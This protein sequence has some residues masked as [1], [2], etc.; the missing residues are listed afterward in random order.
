M[1]E[2]NNLEAV[3][4]AAAT[5]QPAPDMRKRKTKSQEEREEGQ[6][7]VYL[8]IDAPIVPLGKNGVSIWLLDE[9]NQ[10]TCVKP[11]ELGKGLL[12]LL[13]G[14]EWLTE[15]FPQE[16]LVPGTGKNGKKAEFFV[17]GFDQNDAQMAII[18]A[19]RVK[20]I[21][22][23]EGKVFGRGAHRGRDDDQQLLLHMGNKVLISSAGDWRRGS[24]KV[25]KDRIDVRVE[26][27][28][29]IG[30][31][32]YP[33]DDAL[34]P[35]ASE[36]SSR[37][38]AEQLLKL[39]SKWYFVDG[40]R[41]GKPGPAEYLLLGMVGQM[42]ICGAL[43][44]RSHVWLAGPTASGKSSLQRVIRAI[45]DDWVLRAEDASEAAIRQ[46]LNNDTLAVMI[47]EAEAADNPERQRAMM[48][49]AKKSS[50]GG[51]IL[52]GGA[53]HKGQEFTAQSAFLFSSVLHTPMLGED[54]N[55]F[56]ILDM[57]QVP[58]TIEPFEVGPLLPLWRMVGRKM[59][60][61]M[62]EQWPRFE[63]TLATY[64]REIHSHGYEGRWQD[65][66]G[67]LLACADML[68]FDEAPAHRVP[69][70]ENDITEKL[71]VRMVLPL[72][73]RG[74]VEARSDDE[75]VIA[76]LLSLTIPGSN[77]A[78]AETIGQW[79]IRALE[80]R[81]SESED[82]DRREAIDNPVNHVARNRLKS[83]G[84]RLVTLDKDKDGKMRTGDPLINQ[85]EGA[86]L[87]VA[88]PTCKPLSDLFARTEWANGAWVQSM[89]KINGAQKGLKMRFSGPNADN[90]IAIPLMA[91]K[92]Q[93]NDR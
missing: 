8:P 92:E 63:A 76:Y 90:A 31:K 62:L 87:A 79:I 47:D 49:L 38:E 50:S 83:V 71:W 52:R 32:Y 23:P 25:A 53:D 57:R 44:W 65:T 22:K 85:W 19:C 17:D 93:G 46:L 16:R 27:A 48:N 26:R 30:G 60:R 41:D 28:G 77:G 73:V 80:P 24:G 18:G 35:P 58:A 81:M 20:G 33:A 37:D 88:F 11:Q 54:R 21:F 69:E 75:R 72:M 43:N 12:S 10:I 78:A 36:A 42:F 4:A 70:N 29:A 1:T 55:R 6:K 68:L 45:H 64:K 86:F 59:H 51:K 13:C 7:P 56:A 39:F 9:S 40:G 61:R 15:A 5:P 3:A 74:K 89:S 66:Y 82:G 34:P 14:E 2:P 67:T 84:L 91:L